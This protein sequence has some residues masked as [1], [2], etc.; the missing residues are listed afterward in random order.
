M[1]KFILVLA[2]IFMV[3]SVFAFEG[4]SKKSYTKDGYVFQLYQ[5]DKS[6]NPDWYEFYVRLTSNN[7]EEYF[8]WCF[9]DLADTMEHFKWLE[10]I[11]VVKT[12]QQRENA[13]SYAAAV[14]LGVMSFEEAKKAASKEK[15]ITVKTDKRKDWR[16]YTKGAEQSGSYIN[17]WISKSERQAKNK[18]DSWR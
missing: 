12:E 5:I 16:T 14:L 6:E 3:G 18:Y 1:K 2:M 15:L 9:N 11:K 13:D 7:S 8:T 10:T 4:I 17:Y